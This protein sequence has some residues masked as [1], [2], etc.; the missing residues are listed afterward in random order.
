MPLGLGIIVTVAFDCTSTVSA[1]PLPFVTIFCPDKY[2][3]I[4][5]FFERQIKYLSDFA[6]LRDFS[7]SIH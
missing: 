6:I 1:S 3:R 2:H 5:S 7:D 4:T